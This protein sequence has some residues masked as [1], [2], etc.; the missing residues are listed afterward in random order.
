MKDI[1]P[2]STFQLLFYQWVDQPFSIPPC[3]KNGKPINPASQLPDWE[4]WTNVDPQSYPMAYDQRDR[5]RERNT[6]NAQLTKRPGERAAI[7]CAPYI[8]KGNQGT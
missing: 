7:A 4:I 5:G 2:C 6:T 3:L 1:V 8:T